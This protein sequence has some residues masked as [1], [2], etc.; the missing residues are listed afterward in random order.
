MR[1]GERGQG[2]EFWQSQKKAAAVCDLCEASLLRSLLLDAWAV[3]VVDK[4]QHVVFRWERKL[5][6]GQ[7]PEVGEVG[8]RMSKL[9]LNS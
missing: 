6:M 8:N 2:K 4:S 3:V 7:S 5:C 1:C 9:A